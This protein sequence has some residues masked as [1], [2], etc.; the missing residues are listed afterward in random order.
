MNDDSG[1]L[2]DRGRGR[3]GSG[4]DGFGAEVLKRGEAGCFLREGTAA[5][6]AMAGQDRGNGDCRGADADG[7]AVRP[8]LCWM[9]VR[10]VRRRL[11]R[12]ATA[13]GRGGHEGG[14]G[15]DAGKYPELMKSRASVL[16]HFGVG[17]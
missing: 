1:K 17:G 16:L 3:G 13:E 2:Q 7:P 9:E 5:A 11:T 12:A 4:L 6:E 8:Y 14:W 15:I 10:Q